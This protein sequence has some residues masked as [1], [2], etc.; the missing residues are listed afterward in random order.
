MRPSWVFPAVIL[1]LIMLLF[2][3]VPLPYSESHE[4]YAYGPPGSGRG[5]LILYC[6]QVLPSSTPSPSYCLADTAPATIT[7]QGGNASTWVEVI[8][9]ATFT[10]SD[11]NTT[12]TPNPRA[13]YPWVMVGHGP[14]GTI[15]GWEPTASSLMLLTNSTAGVLMS[16]SWNVMPEF[17]QVW[18]VFAVLGLLLAMVGILLPAKPRAGRKRRRPSRSP[19][20]EEDD[21]E[22]PEPPS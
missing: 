20:P 10:C 1:M 14:S 8:Q 13:T 5:P 17:N 2:V 4:V 7:W 22:G 6:P 18:Q 9:C 21:A 12:V 3:Y 15:S 19:E 11:V 16:L